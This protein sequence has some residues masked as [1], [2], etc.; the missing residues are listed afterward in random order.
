MVDA[1]VACASTAFLLA[2]VAMLM[3]RS[4]IAALVD[5][6]PGTEQAEKVRVLDLEDTVDLYARYGWEIIGR[7]PADPSGINPEITIVFRKPEPAARA[8]GALS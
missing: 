3:R 4:K 5:A 7:S 2:L 8:S 1:L 6:P